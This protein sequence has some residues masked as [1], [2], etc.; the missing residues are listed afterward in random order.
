MKWQSGT[1]LPKGLR[2]AVAVT[3]RLR[4]AGYPVPRYL[5][6]GVAPELGVTYS[7]QEALPGEPL[8]GR[9][10]ARTLDRLLQLNE[11]QRDR[12]LPGPRDWPAPVLRTTFKGGDGFCLLEPMR[13]HSA[14]TRELL[15]E[16]QRM[17]AACSSAGVPA[18]DVVHFDFQGGNILLD[19]DEVSGV[20]DWEGTCAGDRA[21]DLATLFFCQDGFAGPVDPGAQARLWQALRVKT[22]PGLRR[23]YLAHMI[24][25]QVDW[26]I[27]FLTQELVD[28]NMRRADEVL[29]LLAE[30][31]ARN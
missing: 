26:A 21:F 5:C 10:D 11:L 6:Y 25:R 24:H 27:R 16:L 17:V 2:D 19:G 14:A 9:L 30:D 12:A 20:V 13:R 29:W 18:G 4:A 15:G 28:R 1:G 3:Q 23:I 8:G 22:T 7:V 31:S